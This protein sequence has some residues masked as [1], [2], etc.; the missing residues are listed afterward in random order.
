MEG[1]AD[2]AA[3]HEKEGTDAALARWMDE[4][5]IHQTEIEMV[6]AV[7]RE[8][9]KWTEASEVIMRHKENSRTS[10]GGK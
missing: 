4:R 5:H 1:T 9:A 3:R 6:D 10:S 7:K 8:G 2:A